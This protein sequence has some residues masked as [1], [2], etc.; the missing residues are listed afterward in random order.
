MKN[1]RGIFGILTAGI[2]WYLSMMLFFVLS[3]A[4]GILADP[5]IQSRKFLDSF[6]QEPLPRVAGNPL[7]VP[8]GL[9]VI[10]AI[11]GGVF[12]WLNDKLGTGWFRRGIA[13]GLIQWALMIPWFEFYLPFNVM[14][15]PLALVLLE[16]L[17]WL[18]VTLTVGIYL[19]FI[20]NFA[21]KAKGK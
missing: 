6:F 11:A 9:I 4:Q 13:F 18:G 20:F 16:M 14:L 7:I 10:G 21:S 1:F 15:E 17:L 8:I 3:G 2:V 19:S 12:L 5:E